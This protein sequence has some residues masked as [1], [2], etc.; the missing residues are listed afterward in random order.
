VKCGFHNKSLA[1]LAFAQP[2]ARPA[3]TSHV[4]NKARP[5]MG[6]DRE[7][8][9]NVEDANR[10]PPRKRGIL[11][12][13][14]TGKEKGHRLGLQ[15]AES[16]GVQFFKKSGVSIGSHEARTTL[17]AHL[18]AIALAVAIP[19]HL[20]DDRLRRQQSGGVGSPVPTQ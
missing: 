10:V 18:P 8:K 6:L 13:Q 15:M 11:R 5:S 2:E 16:C 19:R 9:I 14:E 17:K 3:L 7:P 1:I 12:R 20:S 4:H